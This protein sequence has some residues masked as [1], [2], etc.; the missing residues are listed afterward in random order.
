V[1]ARPPLDRVELAP[2][3]GA[4]F[5]TR[6]GGV[7]TGPYA[8]LNL[9]DHVG[10]EPAAVAENRRL[11]S[12]ALGRPV[13]WLDQVHGCDVHDVD[14]APT[15]APDD[16]VVADA[17]LTSAAATA[18][19]V[20]VADCVPVLLASVDGSAVAVAHA[21]RRGAAAG[22][23]DAAVAALRAR[24]GHDVRAALGPAVCGRCYEVPPKLRDEVD[25]ALPG[26]AATSG[27]SLPSL[28]LR[29]GLRRRLHDLDVAVVDAPDACT[30]ESADHFSFRRDGTTGRTAGVVWRA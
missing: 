22:V 28:D 11:L 5:T 27:R 23:V 18:L 10:D 2:G 7:S 15:G 26:S 3:V 8:S 30:V 13:R 25:S 14:A 9:G 21:G 20:L 1:A 29:A 24:A 19:G 17:A 4:A 6:A 16:R 12:D